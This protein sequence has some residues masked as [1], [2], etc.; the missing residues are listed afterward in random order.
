MTVIQTSKHSFVKASPVT[1][2]R[3]FRAL[4]LGRYVA[5]RT[6]LDGRL[7]AAECAGPNTS[8]AMR[9]C[10]GQRL[11]V[12]GINFAPGACDE[13][14]TQIGTALHDVFSID[15]GDDVVATPGGLRLEPVSS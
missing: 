13:Q 8:K 1:S 5:G 2:V 7:R 9:E 12:T 3:D 11:T 15:T 14:G 4:D 10:R 6:A